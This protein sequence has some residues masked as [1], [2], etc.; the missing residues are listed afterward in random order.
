MLPHASQA[1][2]SLVLWFQCDHASLLSQDYL[3]MPQ[4]LRLR[5]DTTN[6]GHVSVPQTVGTPA[7][8]F[9]QRVRNGVRTDSPVVAEIRQEAH[10]VSDTACPALLSDREQTAADLSCTG[11]LVARTVQ[12]FLPARRFFPR[13]S[14]S[15]DRS[16]P[17][18]H[19]GRA[20][21]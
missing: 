21:S 18:P 2:D 8:K 16:F 11:F 7:G 13:T 20:L 12:L 3:P 5:S 1:K 17:Q 15:N 4:T 6:G 9:L 10:L 19:R 14:R